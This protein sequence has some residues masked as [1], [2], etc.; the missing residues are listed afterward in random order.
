MVLL[1]SPGA[2][3]SSLLAYILPCAFHL[4]FRWHD[5]GC[6]VRFKDIFIIIFGILASLVSLYTTVS[7]IAAKF[8]A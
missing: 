1:S 4:K 5:I 7:E 3:G 2:I 8:S 6:L